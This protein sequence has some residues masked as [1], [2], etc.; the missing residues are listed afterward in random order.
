MIKLNEFEN[1]L[2]KLLRNVKHF[3]EVTISNME[4]KNKEIQ[5]YD[6]MMSI[7]CDYEKHALLQYSDN[8]ESNLLFQNTKNIKNQEKILLLVK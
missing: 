2:N 8:D 1:Y 6:Y 7:L 5:A 4:K 3:S